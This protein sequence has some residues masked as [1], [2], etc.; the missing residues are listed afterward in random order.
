VQVIYGEDEWLLLTAREE[1]LP[2]GL[3]RLR[4]ARFWTECR[5]PIIAPG[6][7][8][9]LEEGGL[10]NLGIAAALLESQAY[11]GGK[12]LGAVT[13][14]DAAVVPQQAQNREIG[15][16]ATVRQTPPFAEGHLLHTE[17]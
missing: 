16:S 17:A 14:G 10:P 11:L 5:Q 8:E 7:P 9:E 6:H 4:A 2:Q 3:E 1:Q 15:Y 13:L 12:S